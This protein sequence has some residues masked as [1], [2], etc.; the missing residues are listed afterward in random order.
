MAV[1]S[2]IHPLFPGPLDVIADVHGEISA[3]RALLGHLG[4]DEEGRHAQ[5]RR[6][7]LPQEPFRLVR[8]RLALEAGAVFAESSSASPVMT[9]CFHSR[10]ECARA[11]SRDSASRLPMRLTATRKAS[12][13]VGRHAI[14]LSPQGGSPLAHHL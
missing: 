3:L 4:Y 5:G 8:P 1:P 10:S 14:P 2:L 6:P 9:N 13:A 12:S 7:V 11:N